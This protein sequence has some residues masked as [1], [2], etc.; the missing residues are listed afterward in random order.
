[1]EKI[2]NFKDRTNLE[3]NMT[4][5]F[6]NLNEQLFTDISSEQAAMIQGGF[7]FVGYD[8]EN[9]QGPVLARAD[10]GIPNLKSQ[11]ISSFTIESG[12]WKLYDLPNY[13]GNFYI[14]DSKVSKVFTLKGTPINNKV[15]SIL[16]A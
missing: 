1:M 16:K 5:V 7:N 13:K 10:R 14:A 15:S 11:G 9:L 2:M 4:T 12:K 8:G 3:K 6:D